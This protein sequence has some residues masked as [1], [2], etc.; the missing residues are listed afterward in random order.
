MEVEAEGQELD[1]RQTFRHNSTGH[2]EWNWDGLT[3]VIE[4]NR[5]SRA[6]LDKTVSA[7]MYECAHANLNLIHMRAYGQPE[8]MDIAEEHTE[9]AIQNLR[10]ALQGPIVQ[11]PR[12]LPASSSQGVAMPYALPPPP[13]PPSPEPKR[14]S[15]VSGSYDEDEDDEVPL[16]AL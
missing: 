13:P 14:Q 3:V 4:N 2:V 9:E 12:S 8:E 10:D 15:L 7:E 1:F 16:T 11:M 6:G 5:M